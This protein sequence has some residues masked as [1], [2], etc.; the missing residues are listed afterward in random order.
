MMP[1]HIKS[2]HLVCGG[3]HLTHV[4]FV[5]PTMIHVKCHEMTQRR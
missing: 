3:Q 1:D 4:A 5:L 2:N